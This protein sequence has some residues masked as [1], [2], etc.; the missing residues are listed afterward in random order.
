M[1]LTYSWELP[2]ESRAIVAPEE[3]LGLTLADLITDINN[4]PMQAQAKPA[5]FGSHVDAQFGT[6]ITRRSSE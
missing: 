2:K 5:L 3:P 1:P 6:T 4:H